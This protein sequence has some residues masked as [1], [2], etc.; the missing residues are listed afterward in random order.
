MHLHVYRSRFEPSAQLERPY[1]MV[2]VNVFAADS[3]SE[4]RRLI[5]SLQQQFVNLRRGTP[6]PLQPPVDNMD[7]IWS[8]AERAGVEQSLAVSV[9]GT[10]ET[11]ERGL[12]A[13]IAQTGADELMVTGQIYDHAAR[14]RSFEIAAGVRDS[15]GAETRGDGGVE[16]IT[17]KVLRHCRNEK[18]STPRLMFDRR[19]GREYL[20]I[21]LEPLATEIIEPEPFRR[22]SGYIDDEQLIVLGDVRFQL[23]PYRQRRM[24]AFHDP[25]G[26]QVMPPGAKGL[27]GLDQSV[28]GLAF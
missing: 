14:L 3:D 9:V 1:A 6:G 27:D 11:V 18:A 5:T 22:V 12:K 2:G 23:V 28:V 13:L 20:N 26:F 21:F 8:P 16:R 4:A 7:D 10:P 17:E 15:L 24:I 19:R 25:D